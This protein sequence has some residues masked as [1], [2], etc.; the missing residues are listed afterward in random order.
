[1]SVCLFLALSEKLR[2]LLAGILRKGVG[3]SNFEEYVFF[4]FLISDRNRSF[5]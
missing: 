1:M 3:T 5:I 4:I 2:L